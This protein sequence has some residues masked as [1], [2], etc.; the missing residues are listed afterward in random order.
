MSLPPGSRSKRGCLKL[1]VSSWLGSAYFVSSNLNA[2]YV[3]LNSRS[4]M[5][6]SWQDEDLGLNEKNSTCL[7]NNLV[8]ALWPETKIRSRLEGKNNSGLAESRAFNSRVWID[9]FDF[10]LTLGRVQ[11][12]VSLPL[13]KQ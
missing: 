10:L 6:K 11:V 13:C 12:L 1:R 4:R 5:P 8:T 3:S 7:G 2:C 9:N